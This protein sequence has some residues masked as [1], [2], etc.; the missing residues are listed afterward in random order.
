MF[1]A[2]TRTI[3]GDNSLI[4]PGCRDVIRDDSLCAGLDPDLRWIITCC[5]AADPNNRPSLADL[6][7][8]SDGYNLWRNN[9]NGPDAIETN[10][11]ISGIIQEYI[12]NAS[13]APALSVTASDPMVLS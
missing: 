1:L 10:D 13:T 3:A 8:A 2:M 6:L 9:E 12:L 5:L 4:H 11:C 7:S